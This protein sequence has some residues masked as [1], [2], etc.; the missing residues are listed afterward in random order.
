MNALKDSKALTPNAAT[1]V[2]IAGSTVV[3]TTSSAL[4]SQ[5]AALAQQATTL[6]H[7]VFSSAPGAIKQAIIIFNDGRDTKNTKSFNIDAAQDADIF[8]AEKAGQVPNPVGPVLK[9]DRSS[10]YIVGTVST[11]VAHSSG[12]SE[13]SESAA[14]SALQAKRSALLVRIKYLQGRGVGVKPYLDQIATID[15]RSKETGAEAAAVALGQLDKTISDQ[16]K[17]LNARQTSSRTPATTAAAAPG[18]GADVDSLLQS[19]QDFNGTPKDY[20]QTLKKALMQ[21]EFGDLTVM[22]GP[23]MIERARIAKRIREYEG[24]GRN[25][26]GYKNMFRQTEAM[27]DTKDPRKM[28][29]IASN[30]R[31]L[32]GQLSLTDFK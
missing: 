28:S 2:W 3:V 12:S 4:I 21:K 17:T 19:M 29:E 5:D 14:A 24:Q 6:G 20:Q 22:S 32:Q 13:S 25:M 26:A 11:S 7:S 8:R 9:G 10:T 30:V 18:S 31:Y 27:I 15:Q 23:F 1:D 16:E